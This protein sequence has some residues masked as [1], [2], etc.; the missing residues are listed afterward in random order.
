MLS[1]LNALEQKFAR[2]MS[3]YPDTMAVKLTGKQEKCLLHKT[4]ER[5]YLRRNISTLFLPNMHTIVQLFLSL[6]HFHFIKKTCW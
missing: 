5:L 3:N 6:Y 2:F 1:F 4:L